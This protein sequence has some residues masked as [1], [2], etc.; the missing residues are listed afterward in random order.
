MFRMGGDPK[1]K[2]DNFFS[3]FKL[4]Q[5]SRQTYY[6]TALLPYSLNTFEAAIKHHTSNTTH[7]IHRMVSQ[8]TAGQRNSIR[9]L[10]MPLWDMIYCIEL[11][12]KENPSFLDMDDAVPVCPSFRSLRELKGVERV[13]LLYYPQADGYPQTPES[14]ALWEAN[15]S[16][17][18]KRGMEFRSAVRILD[19]YLGRGVEIMINYIMIEGETERMSEKMH[20]K[21]W[22]WKSKDGKTTLFGIEA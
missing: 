13:Q 4:S 14:A 5:V 6:E 7:P 20:G 17:W 10:I 22:G 2:K 12:K 15:G 19:R 3:L 21:L 1:G 9:S 8:L 11:E 18:I 16:K